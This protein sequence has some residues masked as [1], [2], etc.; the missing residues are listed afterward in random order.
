[1]VIMKKI[2]FLT[3]TRA[4]FGKIKS[5]LIELNESDLFH[6]EIFITGMH[7][8]SKYGATFEEV[9]LLEIG[10]CFKFVNQSEN[11]AMDSILSKTISGFGDYVREFK[12]DLIIVHGDRVE[13]LAGASVGSLNNIHTAHIEGGEISGTI[14]ELIRHAVSKLSHSHFVSN[15]EAKKRLM[16]MGEHE[17]NIHVIGS[18]DIDLMSSDSLPKIEM[19]KERYEIDYHDYSI[20]MYHPVTTDLD[21]LKL[22]IDSF[23]RALVD[24]EK[25]Y[26]LIY[27]N[28]DLGT[29]IIIDAYSELNENVNFRIFPSM[30]FEYFLSLMKNADFI[31]GN[32][33]AGIREAPYFGIPTIDIGT[34]QNN[35][36]KAES[37]CHVSNN[38]Q[39]IITAI[40]KI[41]SRKIQP[42]S[43]F[44]DGN[45]A[46]LFLETVSREKFWNFSPQKTF[47][48]ID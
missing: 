13:A 43:E 22:D 11:D 20:A 7:M 40:S 8:L 37:I 35:R 1:M 32:S 23:V 27:P 30:R 48:D 39:E 45:S 21:N 44:G 25:N 47:N 2:L 33:S 17:K 15:H 18:P 6:I 9:E 24:S 10:H 31:I 3:G 14:D 46:K 19:V 12:P 34:R 42:S 36:S 4:D 38:Y 41:G 16:N 28:N 5:I 29:Q 26:I